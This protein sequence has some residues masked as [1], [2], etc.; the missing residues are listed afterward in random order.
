MACLGQAF[1][2]PIHC[3]SVIVD[4]LDIYAM[5]LQVCASTVYESTA[6][7]I[8]LMC[9]ESE[10]ISTFYTVDG[11]SNAYRANIQSLYYDS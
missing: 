10:C 11:E 3:E 1:A 5:W 7:P 6:S 9:Q 8:V 4:C 2:L